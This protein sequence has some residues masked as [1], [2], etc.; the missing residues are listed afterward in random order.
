MLRKNVKEIFVTKHFKSLT[1][2]TFNGV[3]NLSWAKKIIKK[4]VKMEMRSGG[5]EVDFQG[6]TYSLKT[7]NLNM[8]LLDIYK[9]IF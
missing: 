1:K 6:G 4:K 2:A 3:D 5:K 7:I 8:F 9:N